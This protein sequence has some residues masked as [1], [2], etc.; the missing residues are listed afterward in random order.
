M[1][2]DIA[3]LRYTKG[4][5]YGEALKQIQ[6]GGGSYAAV[7]K[8]QKRLEVAQGPS[9]ESKQLKEKEDLIKQLMDTIEKLNC[10]INDLER[11]HK[12]KKEKKR[13]KRMQVANRED[14]KDDSVSDMETDSSAKPTAGA[15]GGTSTQVCSSQVSGTISKSSVPKVHKRHHTTEIHPPTTKKA[16]V[17]INNVLETMPISTESLN[18]PQTQPH[19]GQHNNTHR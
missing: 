16:P 13:A 7:S 9:S 6:L 19:N 4:I 10:R 5:S 12:E 17:M 14:S 2:K 18:P 8:V 1:E 15:V 11:K 3:R